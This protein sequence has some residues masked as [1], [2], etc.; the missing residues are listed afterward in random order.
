MRF[1]G[2]AVAF[3]VPTTLLSTQ[4]SNTMAERFDGFPV[5]IEQMS[6][7]KSP[8]EQQKVLSDLRRGLVDIVVGTHRLLQK[9]VVFKDLGL[10]IIDEQQRFGVTH[11]ERLK[12][13]AK[14]VDVL[15]LTATPI[16]RTLNMAMRGF[17]DMSLLEEPPQDRQPVQRYVR[18]YSP[19]MVAEAIRKEMRRGGQSFYL[20]NRVDTIQK[21][22][23]EI[24]ALL[25]EAN[26]LFAHGKM[27]SD[28]LS[29]IFSAF[30]AGEGDV[31]VCTTIIETG[32]DIPNVNT[33]IIG[34]ADKLGLAQLYQIRGRVGRSPKRAY[35]YFMY[36][37]FRS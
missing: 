12:E 13:L 22:A 10:L 6:R 1:G 8:K 25:P 11:K 7:F 35:A 24:K 16:P 34:E 18:D 4:H 5:R 2:Q 23:A 21:A 3:L 33:L 32:I 31:L 14:S 30:V 9:D 27:S 28:D 37:P 17:R 15:T 36:Q 19:A 29:D 20:H 26:I